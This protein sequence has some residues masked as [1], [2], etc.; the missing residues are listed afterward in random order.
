VAIVNGDI[1]TANQYTAVAFQDAYA[2]SA[3]GHCGGESTPPT[4]E[5]PIR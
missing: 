4:P 1:A 5:S 3:A 2:A